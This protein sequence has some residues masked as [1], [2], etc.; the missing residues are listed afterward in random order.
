MGDA[1][2]AIFIA[3][4]HRENGVLAAL[5]ARSI[6]D[7]RLAVGISTGQFY[8]G[9]IGHPDFARLDVI[10]DFVNLAARVQ[11]WAGQHTAT[12]MAATA[13]T[14]SGCSTDIRRGEAQEIQIKG[15]TNPVMVHEV[16]PEGS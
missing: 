9:P 16:L 8:M 3:G 11:A 13:E 4:N 14:M 10:G 5:A 6:S 7:D 1:F 2:L 12:G 15:K